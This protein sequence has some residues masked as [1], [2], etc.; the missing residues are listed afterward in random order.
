MMIIVNLYDHSPSLPS[1]SLSLFPNLI[2][3]TSDL[4]FFF[5][6]FKKIIQI[7]EMCNYYPQMPAL[8]SPLLPPFTIYSL[9]PLNF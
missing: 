8:P 1:L 9:L 5:Y 4:L 2:L 6:F 7:R 3:K